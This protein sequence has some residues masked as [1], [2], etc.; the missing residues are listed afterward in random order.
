MGSYVEPPIGARLSLLGAA[1]VLPLLAC[2]RTERAEPVRGDVL[3]ADGCARCHG[4]DGRG[5]AASAT[6]ATGP[7]PR[8]FRD[9]A[10]HAQRRDADLRRTII[11]GK[12]TAMPPFGTTFDDAQ[13]SALVA[14]L[15]SLDP[16]PAALEPKPLTA[17]SAGG[18]KE[19]ERR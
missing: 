1:L 7:T 11:E 5:V 16:G 10:F 3:F 18:G 6:A 14:H 9:H 2:A 4:K 8:N 12:G 19:A 13:L 15:R 17:P